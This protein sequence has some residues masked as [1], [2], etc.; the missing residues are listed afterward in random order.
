MNDN[1]YHIDWSYS[2]AYEIA[3][4][5]DKF[6]LSTIQNGL[7][8]DSKIIIPKKLILEALRTYKEEHPDRYAFWLNIED[9]N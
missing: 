7:Y 8:K 4:D 6:V 2:V 3:E 1:W 9:N 5:L